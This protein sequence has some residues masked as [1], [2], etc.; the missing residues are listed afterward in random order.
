MGSTGKFR[1]RE[2][3][4]GPARRIR[5]VGDERAERRVLEIC[6]SILRRLTETEP[7]LAGK[8]TLRRPPR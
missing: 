7:G 3:A 1:D 4:R 5:G 6:D 8:I 2:D